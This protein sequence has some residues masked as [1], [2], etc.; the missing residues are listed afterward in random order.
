M[1]V[2]EFLREWVEGEGCDSFEDAMVKKVERFKIKKRKQ[3]EKSNCKNIEDE[4]S[5]AVCIYANSTLPKM[6]RR[7]L[8]RA[9]R[10]EGK[11]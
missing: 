7:G 4:L 10:D 2:K 6:Y 3:L 1:T 9:Y 5:M 11:M 8:N